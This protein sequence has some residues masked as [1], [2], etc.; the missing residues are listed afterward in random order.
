MKT[1]NRDAIIRDIP[2]RS[3][4]FDFTDLAQPAAAEAAMAPHRKSK[5]S[6]ALAR[7]PRDT[8]RP[9][10]LSGFL[11]GNNKSEWHRHAEISSGI[12][13]NASPSLSLFPFS[14]LLG[15]TGHETFAQFRVSRFTSDW[16]WIRG[17]SLA[18]FG[19][20]CR[21]PRGRV[22][23]RPGTAIF[24]RR[25]RI[26]FSW[27]LKPRRYVPRTREEGMAKRPLHVRTYSGVPTPSLS[28]FLERSTGVLSLSAAT[29]HHRQSLAV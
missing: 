21:P 5:V 26:G 9:S 7:A 18:T 23:A 15:C 13:P 28:P 20:R 10:E 17:W 2:T 16:H 11:V 24:R 22:L 12:P 6:R 29:D 3:D 25:F 27:S 14:P 8:L 4:S 1:P 19:A